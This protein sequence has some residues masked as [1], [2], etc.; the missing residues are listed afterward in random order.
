VPEATI[1]VSVA[2]AVDAALPSVV[3]PLMRALGADLGAADVSVPAAACRHAE[4]VA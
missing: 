2:N 3:V 4:L 1:E